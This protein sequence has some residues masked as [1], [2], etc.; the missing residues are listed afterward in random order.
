MTNQVIVCIF[1]D[2]LR[3]RTN[4]EERVDCVKKLIEKYCDEKRGPSQGQNDAA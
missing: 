3:F 4:D 1:I 2:L